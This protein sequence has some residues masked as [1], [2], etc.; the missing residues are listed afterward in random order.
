ML[1]FQNNLEIVGY[2]ITEK[3]MRLSKVCGTR[4]S[5]VIVLGNRVILRCYCVYY[6]NL[7]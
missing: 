5:S 7:R 2:I 3:S 1:I 4:R 6:F